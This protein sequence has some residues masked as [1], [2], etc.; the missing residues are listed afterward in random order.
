[1]I[2]QKLKTYTQ[3]LLS[4]VE[5]QDDHYV[6]AE[7]LELK[8]LSKECKAFISSEVLWWA[9]T[10]VLR[11]DPG[12]RFPIDKAHVHTL[13]EELLSYYQTVAECSQTELHDLLSMFAESYLNGLF[14]PIATLS[15]FVFRNADHK[16][17][18]EISIRLNAL[19]IPYFD[20][21]EVIHSMIDS[22]RH[23]SSIIIANEQFQSA[24]QDVFRSS[25]GRLRSDQ[26]IDMLGP[27]FDFMNK[28]IGKDAIPS[29]LLHAFF[30]EAG[31]QHIADSLRNSHEQGIHTFAKADLLQL[32]ESCIGHSDIPQTSIKESKTGVISSRK[33]FGAKGIILLTG[34]RLSIAK[35]RLLLEREL[36]IEQE[37]Y[38]IKQDSR[39]EIARML[40]D[41]QSHDKPLRLIRKSFLGSLPMN[42][43]MHY[44]NAVFAGDLNCMRK[45]GASIDKTVGVEAALTTCKAFIRQFGNPVREAEDPME[46]LYNLIEMFCKDRDN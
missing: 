40:H 27:L 41:Y 20:S 46:G 10:A 21:A 38:H 1:M 32:L 31:Q 22:K 42:I 3:Q 34:E 43:Q 2:E 6:I 36:Q 24:C 29:E 26:V 28:T 5:T 9:Y 13:S 16:S 12:H 33:F 44:A 37:T 45:L 18:Q 14:R 25:I 11:K 30:Q 8:T 7:V 15:S 17:A 35:R 39:D 23:L 19:S 4:L